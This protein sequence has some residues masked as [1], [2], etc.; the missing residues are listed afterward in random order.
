MGTQDF[1]HLKGDTFKAHRFTFTLSNSSIYDFTGAT[2]K[3]Q[4][5]KMYGDQSR[6]T[7]DSVTGGITILN[8]T[9]TILD[10]EIDE[11]KIDI[12]AFDYIYDIEI[13]MDG[14]VKT[15]LGGNFTIIDTV[16]T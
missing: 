7:F 6:L 3:I 5:K 1:T 2:V 12:L 8:N 10:F 9:S 4:L 14:V 11:Q 16:T 15:W 13:N